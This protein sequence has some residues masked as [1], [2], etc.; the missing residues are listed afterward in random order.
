MLAIVSD[1]ETKIH[2]LEAQIKAQGEAIEKY[3][4]DLEKIKVKLAEPTLR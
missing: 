4:I 1:I 3:R 2:E